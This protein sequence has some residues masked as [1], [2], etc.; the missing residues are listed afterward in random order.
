MNAARESVRPPAGR[1]LLLLIVVAGLFGL[2]WQFLSAESGSSREELVAEAS[3]A[4][5]QGDIE[6]AYAMVQALDAEASDPEVRY[7]LAVIEGIRGNDERALEVLCTLPDFERDPRLLTTAAQHALKVP[8]LIAARRHL[9]RALELMPGNEEAIR[10]LS[11]LEAN[12]MNV[13]RVRQLI[14][15]L[16]GLGRCT[17]QDVFLF[18]AGSRVSY[19]LFENVERLV[20]ALQN[21]PQYGELVYSLATNYLAMDRRADAKRLLADAQ[22]KLPEQ[23][24]WMV[25]LAAAELAILD[26]RMGDA[27]L[28]LAGVGQQGREF[29]PYWLA[30]GRTLRARGQPDAAVRAY[31]N[32]SQL[33]P[34]DPEPVYAL[35]VLLKDEAPEESAQLRVRMRVLQQLNTQVESV[36]TLSSL[37]EAV[38]RFPTLID[39]LVDAGAYREA[40]VCLTWL[41]QEGYRSTAASEVDARLKSLVSLPPMQLKVPRVSGLNDVDLSL[42]DDRQDRQKTPSVDTSVRFEDVTDEFRLKFDYSFPQR[43]PPTILESLGGG[44]A[45]FDYD[46]DGSVDLF[47]PQAGGF[48][49]AAGREDQDSLQRQRGFVFEDVSVLAGIGDSAYGHGVSVADING[50]GFPD[51]FVTNYGLNQMYVNNG[52]GTFHEV[53]V[54]AGV[55]GSVWSVSSAFGDFDN[56]GDPDLYVANYLQ[57]ETCRD[58]DRGDDDC[59]PTHIPGVQDRLYE[60]LGDGRFQDITTEAGLV[61][62][63]GKG[64]GVV[65]RDFDR[66]GRLDLFVGNDTTANRLFMNQTGS[67]TK[68]ADVSVQ[69]GVALAGDGTAEASMGIVSDDL[70]GSGYPDIF[71]TNFETQTNSFYANLDGTSF[72]DDTAA[73]D[74]ARTSYAA[75]GWGTQLLDYNDDGRLDLFVLNGQ[76]HDRPMRPQVYRNDADTFS[77]QSVTEDN[78]LGMRW[79]GRGL[80]VT[81]FNQDARPDLIATHRRGRPHLLR[82]QGDDG[83]RCS[84]QLVAADG[85]RGGAG[86][87]VTLTAGGRTVVRTLHCGG[88]Y[89][90]AN[91]QRLWLVVP[92]DRRI[93]SLKVQ[94]PSG[95]TQVFSDIRLDPVVTLR[96]TDEPGRLW[97]QPR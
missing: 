37:E 56:D 7:L 42:L 59:G 4:L 27:A 6:Q 76:L 14:A 36:V 54:A 64:L 5:Q 28:S 93:D 73:R 19:D 47:F 65:V 77:L 82:N 49:E 48:P 72:V 70:N 92:A 35:S 55:T 15:A 61:V 1:L 32:A 66:D 83:Q 86:T 40:R 52:D 51:L 22:Q 45:A 3:A 90:V 16:D 75:M 46:R 94:W 57:R 8:R 18:C 12:L 44:V 29:Q 97:G 50:D 68:F 89:L 21:D 85:N 43:E 78:Y 71:V 60:N 24:A 62:P 26:S 13:R 80:A 11:N 33:D 88:G 91:Q 2:A 30:L 53:G 63:Q 31:Q 39:R 74:L 81:D 69:S 17:A 20:P 23:N 9:S 79:A 38:E 87:R 25:H 41:K 95:R 96:E 67:A 34:F 10:L 84:L 58:E